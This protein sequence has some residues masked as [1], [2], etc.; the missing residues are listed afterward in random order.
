MKPERWTAGTPAYGWPVPAVAEDGMRCGLDLRDLEREAALVRLFGAHHGHLVRLAVLLGAAGDAEDV[1]ADA[2]YELH[3]KWHRLRDADAAP[4]YLRA[5]VYNLVRMRLRHLQV[6]RKHA[7]HFA[8]DVESA[9]AAALWREDQRSV[10]RALQLLAPRQREAVVL[11]YWLDLKEAEIADMMGI[12]QG[13]VKSHMSRAM[14]ALTR[15]M[16][17][18]GN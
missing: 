15:A 12:S 11:R 5:T 7:D 14:A 2:F 8:G 4:A 3:R 9:E 6:E 13:A 17:A 1:V 18:V 10:L 16:Q